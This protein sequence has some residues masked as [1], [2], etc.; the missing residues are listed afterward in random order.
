MQGFNDEQVING[1]W[2]ECWFDSE[3]MAEVI[4]VKGE[5]NAEYTD[6]LR[7]GRLTKG[8]KLTGLEGTGEVKLHKV[9]STVAKKVLAS[10]KQGKVPKY[11]IISKL[12]DPDS[13]GTERVAFYN[14]VVDKAI[15]A[16]WEAGK[17]GEETYGFTFTDAEY[18]DSID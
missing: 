12:A 18:L 9:S 17:N 2:G 7:V 6:I 11:T 5:Y 10:F 4:S 14:C 1:T 3:Y 13:S 8:K 16:D 15:L